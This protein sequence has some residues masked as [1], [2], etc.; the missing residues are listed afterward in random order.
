[1]GKKNLCNTNFSRWVA[2][3]NGHDY[4][5]T[6]LDNIFRQFDVKYEGFC[7][8]VF[9]KNFFIMRL[10]FKDSSLKLVILADYEVREKDFVV[11]KKL[12][13]EYREY[14]NLY[15]DEFKVTQMNIYSVH[16]YIAKVCNKIDY[17]F[18]RYTELLD[19]Q[20]L[21]SSNSEFLKVGINNAFSITELNELIQ[22]YNSLYSIFYCMCES[23]Y[24][25]TLSKE[26][27]EVA[28][29]HTMILESIN[30]GSLGFLSSV[31]AGLVVE[32]VKAVV[33]AALANDKNQYE[34][35]KQELENRVMNNPDFAD[36]KAFE[37]IQRLEY[38]LE[39]RENGRVPAAYIEQSIINTMNRIEELQGTTHVDLLA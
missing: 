39:Q 29:V 12:N 26:V 7:A 37:L 34:E 13:H 32:L 5:V 21:S 28:N 4:Y 25:E 10:V 14:F 31:G 38:L 20:G 15:D 35:K 24:E 22:A 8:Y 2:E 9:Y 27:D 18:D 19:K 36:D 6:Q 16:K 3:N 23:G 1:M 17:G 11:Q 33:T 30:I